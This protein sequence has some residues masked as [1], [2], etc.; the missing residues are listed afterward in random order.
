MY[1]TGMHVAVWGGGRARRHGEGTLAGA[2]AIGYM[3]EFAV[4]VLPEPSP[5][6]LGK[7]SC[8]RHSMTRGFPPLP[9]YG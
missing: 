3:Y 6:P 9:L 1:R 8:S 2:T 7:Q 4:L 5:V